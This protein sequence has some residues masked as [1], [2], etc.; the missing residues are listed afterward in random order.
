MGAF[1]Q[2][3]DSTLF[4]NLKFYLDFYFDDSKIAETKNDNPIMYNVFN[5]DLERGEVFFVS[6]FVINS[7]DLKICMDFENG[8]RAIDKF[9]DE[10]I[11]FIQWKEEYFGSAA[12][13]LEYPK[14]TGQAVLIKKDK[15]NILLDLY[16]NELEMKNFSLPIA[17]E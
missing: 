1:T 4:N 11:K 15:L 2:R 17:G 9:G 14:N 10:I 12:D 6:P 13:G 8:L 16:N 3:N 5:N 7:M